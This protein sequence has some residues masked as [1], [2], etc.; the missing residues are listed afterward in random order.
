[1]TENHNFVLKQKINKLMKSNTRSVLETITFQDY[2]RLTYAFCPSKTVADNVIKEVAKAREAAS[3][4]VK[5]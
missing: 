4:D 2:K 5:E 3:V 1:M